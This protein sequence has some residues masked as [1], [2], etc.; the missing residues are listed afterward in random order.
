[1]SS[2]SVELQN[3]LYREIRIL[4]VLTPSILRLRP[5]RMTRT[6][7]WSVRQPRRHPWSSSGRSADGAIR[8]QSTFLTDGTIENRSATFTLETQTRSVR[9]RRRNATIQLFG[10]MLGT[11]VQC[12][13]ESMTNCNAQTLGW[14][15]CLGLAMSH[16]WRASSVALFSQRSSSTVAGG[17]TNNSL[18]DL[19]VRSVR[20]DASDLRMPESNRNP[21]SPFLAHSSIPNRCP[22]K[23][24]VPCGSLFYHGHLDEHRA[25]L[26]QSERAVCFP[27]FQCSHRIQ[28]PNSSARL[29]QAG[30]PLLSK[31][32]TAHR[33]GHSLGQ[34]CG[35]PTQ[36]RAALCS[37]VSVDL[38]S[39]HELL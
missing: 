29:V 38:Q 14:W 5:N 4:Q 26:L 28:S 6:A 34:T 37:R 13:R 11:L 24:S 31:P 20:T 22:R 17:S 8:M 30:E 23:A 3:L 9:D 10:V 7:R 33:G 15:C 1:M 19:V 18:A 39:P 27:S 21:P 25:T 12:D 36:R 16:V 2:S 32:I 35:N